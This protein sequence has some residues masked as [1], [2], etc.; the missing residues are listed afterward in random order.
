[1][2]GDL[3]RYLEMIKTRI[4]ESPDVPLNMLMEE[5]T[6]MATENWLKTGNPKLNDKQIDKAVV[7]VMIRKQSLN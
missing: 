2:V 5:I 4:I 7:K 6:E 1:M 3:I